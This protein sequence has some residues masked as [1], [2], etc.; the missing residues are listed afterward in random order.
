MNCRVVNGFAKFGILTFNESI[1]REVLSSVPFAAKH[2]LLDDQ[3]SSEDH[4]LDVL[5][6]V[7]LNQADSN[8]LVRTRICRVFLIGLRSLEFNCEYRSAQGQKIWKTICNCHVM[9]I[10]PT[11]QEMDWQKY[12]PLGNHE[13]F[14]YL[15]L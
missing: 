8:T 1:S 2:G 4:Q 14:V 9:A 6:Q 12:L 15:R 7:M 3:D 13:P 10:R 11:A 5:V